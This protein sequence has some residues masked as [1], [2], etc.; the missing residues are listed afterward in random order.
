MS[1]G[2]RRLRSPFQTFSVSPSPKLTIM[3]SITH[4]VIGVN[5]Y[6]LTGLK[7]YAYSPITCSMRGASR[8]VLEVEQVRRPRAWFAATHPGGP[9][10][11]PGGTMTPPRGARWT[12]T[13]ASPRPEARTRRVS[14][15]KAEARSRQWSA[16]WRARRTPEAP[17]FREG[18]RRLRLMVAPPGAPFPSAFAGERKKAS[19]A[20][21]DGDRRKRR[22]RRRKEYGAGA[23]APDNPAA[24][25][26]LSPNH[27]NAH[28]IK[29][30]RKPCPLSSAPPAA[31]NIRRA[32]RI[33]T[34]RRRYASSARRSGNTCRRAAR[35][36]PR[37]RRS[38]QSHM[39]SFREYEPGVIGI[40]SQPAFAIGQRALLVR[41]PGG[42]VL[43]D[44][45]ATLDAAT[46][47][48]IKGLGGIQAIAI[49]HPHFYTT[50]GEWSARLRRRRSISTP[51]TKT[52]SCS[53]IRRSNCGK[54]TRSNSGTASRWFAA[55]AISRAAPCCIG[56]I[57][58]KAA[59][60][61]AVWSAPATFS[62]S[63]PTASGFRSCAA[64]R[65]SFRCR[66][67]RSSISA[68]ALEP[69][70]FDVIYGHYFDR[71]IAKDAKPVLEKSVAR[72]V[73]AINGTRG[74]K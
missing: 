69:F 65:I 42:N 49:S 71:V 55:A 47:T 44:C 8:G 17:A 38:S 40:G 13:G 64:I 23:F 34:C 29:Y 62:P 58:R 36:G 57:V 32:T 12:G 7:S 28:K 3:P 21:G 5:N 2:S 41:T 14:L 63:P 4:N 18:A 48:M 68:Q 54:A 45:I 51:P 73:G 25:C 10:L 35:A 56:K 70:T 27:H 20:S 16:E 6:H 46:V 30:Q 22:T 61:G 39:N 11:R 50:M 19:P 1:N 52:G 59:R 66:R 9:G 26:K 53:R 33:R 72:Y 37:S 31:R 60:A 15:A 24:I 43:W 67:A 74:Y